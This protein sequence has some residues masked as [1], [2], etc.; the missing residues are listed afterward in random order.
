ML[1][2]APDIPHRRRWS[3]RAIPALVLCVSLIGATPAAGAKPAPAAD[4][5]VITTWNQIA[6]STITRAVADGGR[7]ANAE[8]FMWFA[9]VQAAVYNAV[10]GITGEYELYKWHAK[11]PKGASAQAAAAAAAHRV[12]MNYFGANATIEANLNTA[13]GTSLGLIADSESKD[14]GVRYG[15]RAAD[16][17]I[18]LRADDGRFAPIV[19]NPPQPL[20]AGVW[21]PTA[22]GFAPFFDPWMGQVEPL[23]L[24]SSSQFRPGPPPPINSALYVQEFNEVRDFGRNTP[25]S[26]SGAQTATALYFFDIAVGPIQAGL[27]D[28]VTRHLLDIS[29]SARLFAAV[30]MSIADTAITVWDGKLV[31][32]WWRPITAI[33]LADN[34]GNAATI[35]IPAWEPLVITPPYPDWPSGLSGVIGALSRTLERLNPNGDIDIKITSP[36]IGLRH[37]HSAAVIQQDVIDARVWSGIHFRT[38]DSVGRDMGVQVGNWALDHYFAPTKHNN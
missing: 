16:R 26:R 9:F 3:R 24:D 36:V 10:V 23:M 8:S 4:P 21:R 29:D 17:L 15:E 33:Q 32:G 19:F 25:S 37:Y 34:D 13:L 2:P 11:G 20:A 18:D 5:S 1:Q 12:L 38:T 6:V 30:D 28:L 14:Q 7:G 31:Y 35:G 22:P 27:R